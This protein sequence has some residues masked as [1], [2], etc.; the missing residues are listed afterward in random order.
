MLVLKFEH[1]L[2]T[3]SHVYHVHFSWH[4]WHWM[5]AFQHW[6]AHVHLMLAA[7]VTHPTV[8][9]TSQLWHYASWVL[10]AGSY[11]QWPASYSATHGY[12]IQKFRWQININS[13]SVTTTAVQRPPPPRARGIFP[14]KGHCSS[15]PLSKSQKHIEMTLRH[16]SKNG[17]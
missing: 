15:V 17:W 8:T 5:H 11:Y 12:C 1:G 9:N 13:D 4:H 14:C 10:Q 3:N 6:H 16:L 7:A 2:H